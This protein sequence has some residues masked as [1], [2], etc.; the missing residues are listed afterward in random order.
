M[1]QFGGNKMVVA[2]LNVAV[3][4]GAGLLSFFSPC[5]LPLIPAYM[6]S[7]GVQLSAKEPALKGRLLTM[8]L[9]FVLGFT[10]IFIIMGISAG[11][12]GSLLLEYREALYRLGGVIVFFFGLKQLGI[13]NLPFLERSWSGISRAP[14]ARGIFSSFLMGAIFSLAWSPCA[15]PVLAGILLLAMGAGSPSTAAFYLFV[16][17]MGLAVP[18]IALAVFWDVFLGRLK[19]LNRFHAVFTRLSAVFLL[20][21]GFLLFS[22]LFLKITSILI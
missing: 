18:F 9:A 15:G 10:L 5:V 13:F 11:L 12:L 7:M 6:A 16:Y 3:A 20:L 17:S 8:S 1:I 21:L 14:A 4:F 19:K 22:G 2:D